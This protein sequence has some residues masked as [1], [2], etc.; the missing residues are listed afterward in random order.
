MVERKLGKTTHGRSAKTSGNSQSENRTKDL[1]RF[2]EKPGNSGSDR[3]S[4][5][6]TRL[7]ELRDD[8][9]ELRVRLERVEGT[10]PS[11]FETGI[12]PSVP[13]KPGPARS[14]EDDEL[15]RNRDGL[16]GWLEE[17]W[18][19]IA[20]SLSAALAVRNVD[21]LAVIFNAAAKKKDL[22]PPWQSRFLEHCDVLM[23]FLKSKKFRLKPPR[24][25][26]LDGLNRPPDDERRKRVANRLP[27]RQI[28]NA[29]AGV[30]KLSWS[31]SLDR[32]G[33]N[34]CSYLVATK[35]AEHYRAKFCVAR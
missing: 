8:V 27:T 1:T 32:C 14:I 31:T 19:D 18:P 24:K 10:V 7:K 22:Q 29:M 13:K 23:S 4:E 16:V 5:I 9:T 17:V 21:Q 28:A 12:M 20:K 11:Y 3:F 2:P 6:E 33:R 30:P 26:I 34:P 25:T 15:L 35:T